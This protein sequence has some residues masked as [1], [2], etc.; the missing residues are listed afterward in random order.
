MRILIFVGVFISLF[1]LVTFEGKAGDVGG[2]KQSVNFE[3]LSLESLSS[4]VK[5]DTKPRL[6]STPQTKVAQCCKICKKGKACGN[7]CISRSYTCRKPPGC[8][9]DG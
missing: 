5:P 7:S 3:T 4:F 8:A 6:Q 9:C 2:G 1:A